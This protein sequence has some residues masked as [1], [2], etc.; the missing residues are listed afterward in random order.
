MPHCSSCRHHYLE[1]GGVLMN[2]S[3]IGKIQKAKIYA[4]VKLFSDE[5]D[6]LLADTAGLADESEE[7]RA[8]DLKALIE[9]LDPKDFGKFRF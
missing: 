4:D 5:L 9:N 6:H 8:E 3:M 7:Q 2:S 1:K